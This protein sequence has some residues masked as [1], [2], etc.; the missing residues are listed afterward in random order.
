MGK[1][2]IGFGKLLAL[3][4]FGAG[5]TEALPEK[6]DHRLTRMERDLSRRLPKR[7]FLKS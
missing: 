4:Q 3:L 7:G 1:A 6:L 2:G 5:K